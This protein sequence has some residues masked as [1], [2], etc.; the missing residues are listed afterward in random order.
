MM[1]PQ[2]P[3]ATTIK[4]TDT[5]PLSKAGKTSPH[6]GGPHS[7]SPALLPMLLFACVMGVLYLFIVV[8]APL[9]QLHLSRTPLAEVWP[10][11]LALSRVFFPQAWTST[12]NLSSSL[13]WLYP[14]LLTLI[15]A[16]LLATYSLATWWVYRRRNI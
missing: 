6:G 7:W 12:A 5:A 4:E 3:K 2:H 9:P 10:W 16:A 14:A 8:L 11:T 13:S 15:L 1:E